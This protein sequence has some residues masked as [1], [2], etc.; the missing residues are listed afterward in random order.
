MRQV[1][2]EGQDDLL[3]RALRVYKPAT[4]VNTVDWDW[5]CRR[6]HLP[7][8]TRFMRGIHGRSGWPLKVVD[9]QAS[10]DKLR[11]RAGQ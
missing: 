8:I 4:Y 6:L 9:C 10:F 5:L 7:V 3:N 11:M 1:G 2:A